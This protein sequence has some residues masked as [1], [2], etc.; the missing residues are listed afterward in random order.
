MTGLG[1][2]WC[3]VWRIRTG[4]I[5]VYGAVNSLCKRALD[6]SARWRVNN[7]FFAYPGGRGDWSTKGCQLVSSCSAKNGEVH[8]CKCNHLTNFALLVVCICACITENTARELTRWKSVLCLEGI[9]PKIL[10]LIFRLCWIWVR[11]NSRNGPF[12]RMT[13]SRSRTWFVNECGWVWQLSSCHLNLL[14][15]LQFFTFFGQDHPGQCKSP[16]SLFSCIA[17]TL[18]L[19]V[20]TETLSP[21]CERCPSLPNKILKQLTIPNEQYA[22]QSSQKYIHFTG[23]TKWSIGI[24]SHQSPS[25]FEPL[26]RDLFFS[27]ISYR[28]LRC[29]PKMNRATRTMLLLFIF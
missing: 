3:E 29:R 5:V 26:I 9:P 11:Q 1:A 12:C 25:S 2:K 14:G 7:L 20:G 28:G 22:C 17:F 23:R 16:R 10:L 4:P 13:M 24:L 18:K 6:E 21:V 15:E 8:V 27:S 19:H